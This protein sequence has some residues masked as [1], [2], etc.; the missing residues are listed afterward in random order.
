MQFNDPFIRDLLDQN[1]N[2]HIQ[3]K[4]KVSLFISSSGNSGNPWVE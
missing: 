2:I 4:Y 1:M 3:K